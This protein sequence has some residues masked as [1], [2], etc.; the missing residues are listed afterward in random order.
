MPVLSHRVPKETKAPAAACRL[1]LL[2]Y[3]PGLGF[4][5]GLYNLHKGSQLK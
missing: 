4:Q 2:K 5:K 3:V 1:L